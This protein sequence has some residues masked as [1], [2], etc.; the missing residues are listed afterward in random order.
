MSRCHS[1]P[2]RAFN[3]TSTHLRFLREQNPASGRDRAGRAVRLRRHAVIVLGT[4][5]VGVCIV[6]VYRLPRLEPEKQRAWVMFLLFGSIFAVPTFW[7][8][9]DVSRTAC[10]SLVKRQP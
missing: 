4:E 6:L 7:L 9:F 8:L 10:P 3:R 5:L 2:N 1:A